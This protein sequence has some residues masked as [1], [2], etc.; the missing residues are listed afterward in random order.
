MGGVGRGWAERGFQHEHCVCVPHKRI[1]F[2]NK[3]N[4]TTRK[5]RECNV[6]CEMAGHV[7]DDASKLCNI[8][9]Y[10]GRTVEW[11][12]SVMARQMQRMVR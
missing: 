2:I 10:A 6:V 4:P 12:G 9:Y 3:R 11:S 1:L 5:K 8:Y 7:V